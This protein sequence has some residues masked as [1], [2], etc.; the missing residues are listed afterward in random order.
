[1][2]LLLPLFVGSFTVLL[3]LVGAFNSLASGWRLLAARFAYSPEFRGRSWN[4]QSGQLRWVRY[5]N[6]LTLGANRDGLYLA[7]LALF[8]FRH[9]PLH[10]PWK[11]I[12]ITPKRSFFRQGMEFRLGGE[13]GVPLWVSAA[14]AERL[15]QASL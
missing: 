14:L 13:E 11:E 12:T 9:P 8:R 6:C 3:L 2:T 15:R 10:I 7:I 1:M 4:W 5:R